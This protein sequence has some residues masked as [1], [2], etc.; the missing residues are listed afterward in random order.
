MTPA[1]TFRVGHFRVRAHAQEHSL[2]RAHY[3]LSQKQGVLG[4][5]SGIVPD[6]S[7]STRARAHE[8]AS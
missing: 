4:G 2:Y 8:E 1:T 7:G 5:E 6:S 3:Y